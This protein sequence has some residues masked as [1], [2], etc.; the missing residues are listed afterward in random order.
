MIHTIQ[1]AMPVSSIRAPSD[2]VSYHSPINE[3]NKN[4]SVDSVSVSPQAHAAMRQEQYPP[5][6]ALD[7]FQDWRQAGYTHVAIH[8]PSGEASDEADLLPENQPLLNHIKDKLSTNLTPEAR[9]K[10][11]GELSFLRGVGKSEIFETAS[12]L[13]RR[14]D[15][16]FES[17]YLQQ[18][19]LVEKYGDANGIPSESMQEAIAALK[20]DSELNQR[21][22]LSELTGKDFSSDAPAEVSAL[23]QP[24]GYDLQRFKSDD[25]LME[26]LAEHSEV[27]EKVNKRIDAIMNNHNHPYWAES[28]K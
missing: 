27:F 25:F 5:K 8:Y 24:K 26:L 22:K 17:V 15:A 18:K 6:S 9:A 23:F 28:L 19:Y 14:M 20:S 3:Q 1:T 16:V 2:S 12:E 21:P 11:L 7:L 10:T 4:T 13:N